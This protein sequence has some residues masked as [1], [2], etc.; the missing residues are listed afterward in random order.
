MFRSPSWLDQIE[1]SY[2]ILQRKVLTPNDLTELDAFAER[3]LAFQARY[4]ATATP[5]DWRFTHT[6]STCCSPGSP[7]GLRQSLVIMVGCCCGD[8][9][10][11]AFSR[12]GLVD[13]A[14]GWGGCN[15]CGGAADFC[16]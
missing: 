15:G 12:S 2:S 8:M 4:H 5:F 1:I 9:P 7:P 16:G 14:G 10:E 6:D 13:I 3:I 11:L